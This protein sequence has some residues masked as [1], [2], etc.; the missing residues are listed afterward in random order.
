MTFSVRDHVLCL[1]QRTTGQVEGECEE[2]EHYDVFLD[3]KEVI[4]KHHHDLLRALP[5]KYDIVGD[6]YTIKIKARVG[7]GYRHLQI[8][9]H[10]GG[11][12]EPLRGRYQK[13]IKKFKIER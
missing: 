1:S 6:H 9:T 4:E 3:I 11:Y 7:G 2:P 12:G 8:A 5:A 10:L 13:T